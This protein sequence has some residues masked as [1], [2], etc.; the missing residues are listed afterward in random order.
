MS[1]RYAIEPE[2]GISFARNRSV[3]M[4]SG[5]LIAFIDDDETAGGEWLA[6]LYK[7]LMRTAADAVLG[8]V[9]P[10]YPEGTPQWIIRSRYFERPRQSSGTVVQAENTRTSNAL[11]RTAW[12]RRRTPCCFLPEFAHSGGGDHDFFKWMIAEGGR[13]VWCD[14]ASVFE[15][16]T[17]DRQRLS[18]MLERRFRRSVT[19]WRGIYAGRRPFSILIHIALGLFGGGMMMIWGAMISLRG[20]HRTVRIWA[21]AMGGFGRLFALTNIRLIG[22]RKVS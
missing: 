13:I 8:P 15:I 22:Y 2:Q 3:S 20:I 9:L 7:E 10:E 18:W 14:T 1:V 12:L 16:V 5:E 11:V 19:Y 21:K 6:D 17:R 4:A